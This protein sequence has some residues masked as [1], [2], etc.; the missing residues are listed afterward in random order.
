M[1]TIIGRISNSCRANEGSVLQFLKMVAKDTFSCP[2][3]STWLEAKVNL[4]SSGGSYRCTNYWWLTFRH[5]SFS[6]LLARTI[7]ACLSL[8]PS[9]L[10]ISAILHTPIASRSNCH[11][12]VQIFP[13]FQSGTLKSSSFLIIKRSCPVPMWYLWIWITLILSSTIQMSYISIDN[14]WWGRS[15]RKRMKSITWRTSSTLRKRT[16]MSFC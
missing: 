15:S 16:A 4:S 5:W 9:P 8:S 10:Q 11:P 13:L 6:S 2:K 14:S 12:I 3:Q 1:C 7:P